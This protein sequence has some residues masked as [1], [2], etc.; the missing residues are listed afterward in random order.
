MCQYNAVERTN[1]HL[2]DDSS[3]QNTNLN[4]DLNKLNLAP[5]PEC[6]CG[7]AQETTEDYLIYCSINANSRINLLTDTENHVINVRLIEKL[8]TQLE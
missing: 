4:Y 6:R 5:T 8:L 1:N 7:V 3:K 2:S